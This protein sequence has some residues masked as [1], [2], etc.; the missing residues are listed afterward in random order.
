MTLGGSLPVEKVNVSTGGPL[1]TTPARS[2]AIPPFELLPLVNMS[3]RM[4]Q[5]PRWVALNYSVNLSRRFR[6]P[7]KQ[8][9]TTQ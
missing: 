3:L 6:T 2:K 1:I 5:D 7:S 8:E 9:L 4:A